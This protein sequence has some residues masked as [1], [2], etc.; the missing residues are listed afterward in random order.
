M[1]NG[2][3]DQDVPPGQPGPAQLRENYLRGLAALEVS[4]A[5]D[6]QIRF[7][8]RQLQARK[9]QTLAELATESAQ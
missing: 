1:F 8:I 2:S 4:T 7:L 3:V 6:P 5:T 9:R